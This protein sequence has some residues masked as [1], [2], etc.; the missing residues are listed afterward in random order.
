VKRILALFGK[1]DTAAD[2]KQSL[3]IC[4]IGET[5]YTD[6]AVQAE[7]R[8]TVREAQKG[9]EHRDGNGL[10]LCNSLQNRRKGLSVKE[11]HGRF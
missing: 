6:F 8:G 10:R 5:V 3:R 1:E 9:K 7:L 4:G 11:P 2:A